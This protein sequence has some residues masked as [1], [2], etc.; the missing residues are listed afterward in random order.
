MSIIDIRNDTAEVNT[1][2]F[3][4]PSNYDYFA[5]QLTKQ[6]DGTIRIEETDARKFIAIKDREHL[7][8]LIRALQKAKE[9][10]WV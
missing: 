1:I 3:G 5:E 4:E 8:Y 7:D 9:L 2:I 10:N 6:I